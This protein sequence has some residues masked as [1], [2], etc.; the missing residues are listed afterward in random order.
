[1]E[2]LFSLGPIKGYIDL[3]EIKTTEWFYFMVARPGGARLT[4]TLRVNEGDTDDMLKA[5]CVLEFFDCYHRPNEMYGTYDEWR[6]LLE[7]AGKQPL[8]TTS[9]YHLPYLREVKHL[10]LHPEYSAEGIHIRLK[11]LHRPRKERV[12]A[13]LVHSRVLPAHLV[14]FLSLFT[15]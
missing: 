5:Y 3:S 7:I 10:L 11:L 1:M 13:L 4:D 15:K 8:A 12:L 6:L 2:E 9:V 14:H